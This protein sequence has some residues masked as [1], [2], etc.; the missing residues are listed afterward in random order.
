MDR[1]EVFIRK[2]REDLD[3]Y[4]PSPEIWD[5]I[6]GT[7]RIGNARR[8][9]IW[10]TSAAMIAVIL[11]SAVFFYL[12]EN[13][14]S[15]VRNN[16]EAI[17]MKANPVLREAE[18]YYTSMYNNLINEATPLLTSNPEIEAELINDLSR[19]DSICSNIKK[20]LK[21]NVSNQEVVEA[22]ISN[23]RIKI[24]IL[25]EMLD[26]LKENEK[27]NETGKSYAL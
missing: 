4:T 2:N 1:L 16:A 13:R 24:R 9:I 11:G 10:L 20:D 17:I 14:R 7:P 25:E 6:S 18:I 19:I 27:T 5:R 23:Y 21:D 3:R 26:V 12:G 22:L 8:R 15:L